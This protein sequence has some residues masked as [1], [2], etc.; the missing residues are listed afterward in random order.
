MPGFDAVVRAGRRAGAAAVVL[1]GAGSAMMAFCRKP[2][3]E[4]IGA[5]MVRAMRRAGHGART[6]ILEP[7]NRGAVVAVK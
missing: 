5:A 3:R 2:D 7:D 4:R 1:S 6:L